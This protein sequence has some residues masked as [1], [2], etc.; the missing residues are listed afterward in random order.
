MAQAYKCDRCGSLYEPYG[1]TFK[2]SPAVYNAI[3][4][5]DSEMRASVLRVRF[6]LCPVCMRA[7]LDFLT[8]EVHV[9]GEKV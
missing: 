6:E 5:T 7:V 2:K 1:L 9:D 4:L 8:M 3:W